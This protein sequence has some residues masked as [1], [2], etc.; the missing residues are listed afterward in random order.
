M[1][2]KVL[3]ELSGVSL[4]YLARI[5]G[6]KGNISLQLLE[7][8]AVALGVGIE[9]LINDEHDENFDIMLI[10]EFLRR[11]SPGRVATIRA[12]LLRTSD[13]D[14][15]T[16]HKCIALIGLRGV[17]KSTVGTKLA[18]KL[19]CPLVELDQEI[20][21]DT[22]LGIREIFEQLGQAAFRKAERRC[23]ERIVESNSH[24]VIATAGGI[25]SEPKTFAYLLAN[26]LT[27]YLKATPEEHMRRVVEQRDARI[28]APEIRTEAMDVVKRTLE[29][30]EKLYQC[31]D[32]VVDTT[33]RTA[34]QATRELLRLIPH[35]PPP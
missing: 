34:A 1:T 25:V 33:D 7:Q 10:S 13:S 14:L 15:H 26:A 23:L 9:T 30:R 12:Q 31:A 20:E 16:T 32:L 18:E 27:V 35:T 21:R 4:A 5:E 8:V 11:Q 17:G 3:A 24:V 22:G 29:A 2:R 19:G 6:G 28:T